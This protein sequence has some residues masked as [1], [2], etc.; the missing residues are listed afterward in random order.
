MRKT[1]Q[2]FFKFQVYEPFSIKSKLHLEGVSARAH[3][4]HIAAAANTTND[5]DGFPSL[6][7]PR[8]T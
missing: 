6:R 3:V 5:N 8:R 1:F 7:R 4:P 2:K